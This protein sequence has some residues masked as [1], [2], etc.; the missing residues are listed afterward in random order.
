MTV[1]DFQLYY[2]TIISLDDLRKMNF[3][4][5]EMFGMKEDEKDEFNSLTEDDFSDMAYEF[6][7]NIPKLSVTVLPH[8][9]A[10]AYIKSR[11]DTYGYIIGVVVDDGCSI[12]DLKRA[13]E[14]YLSLVPEVFKGL[15]AKLYVVPDD[16][17]CC[18]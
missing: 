2:G 18:S 17:H 8:D 1:T 9:Y 14:L 11:Y 16:C 4:T 7:L 12:E 5:Y 13:E 15:S 10:R 6:N 3:L